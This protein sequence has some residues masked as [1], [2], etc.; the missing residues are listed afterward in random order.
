MAVSKSR[1]GIRRAPKRRLVLEV[2]PSGKHSNVNP[3]VFKRLAM[4]EG[5][6]T[7]ENEKIGN[8]FSINADRPVSL[9]VFLGL[10]RGEVSSLVPEDAYDCNVKVYLGSRAA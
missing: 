6:V 5:E 10:V 8:V 3:S 9:A 2:F 4:W 1:K 7:V